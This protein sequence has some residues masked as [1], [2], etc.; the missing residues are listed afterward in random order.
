M[1]NTKHS[2]THR[3]PVYFHRAGDT[4][5]YHS[6]SFGGGGATSYVEALSLAQDLLDVAVLDLNLSGMDLPKPDPFQNTGAKSD[7]VK[8]FTVTT[9]T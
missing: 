7:H 9:R 4:W 6:P 5:G 2:E 1:L 3:F 8:W